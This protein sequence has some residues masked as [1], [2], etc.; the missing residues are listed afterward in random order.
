MRKRDA[1]LRLIYS[2]TGTIGRKF[3]GNTIAAK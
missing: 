3:G 1:V 2:V